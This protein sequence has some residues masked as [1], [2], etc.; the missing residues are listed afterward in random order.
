MAESKEVDFLPPGVVH[1]DS[2]G[3]SYEELSAGVSVSPLLLA[4]PDHFYEW[5]SFL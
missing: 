4:W 1:E 2:F 5:M 3:I